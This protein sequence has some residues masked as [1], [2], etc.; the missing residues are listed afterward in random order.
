VAAAGRRRWFANDPDAEAR[1][2]WLRVHQP[3][4]AAL[5]AKIR[6]EYT[7]YYALS[8]TFL[9][10][11]VMASA[12][13]AVTWALASFLAVPLTAWRGAKI[14]ETFQETTGKFHSA[15]AGTTSAFDRGAQDS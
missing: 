2:D 13:G 8:A 14:E 4:A 12:S 9:A 7:M 15:Y 3:A 5:C 1:F 6:A 10:V 11:A